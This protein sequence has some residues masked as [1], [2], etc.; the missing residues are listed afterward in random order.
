[1]PNEEVLKEFNLY[2]L[3]DNNPFDLSG[4]EAQRLALS[5]V[6]S[7]NPDI[8]LLDEPTKSLDVIFKKE[9]Y[10]IL[11]KIANSGKTIIFVTH[12]L[13][14]AGRYADEVSFLFDGKI[15]N[16]SNRYNFFSSLNIYTTSLSRLTNGKIV[17]IDDI[18]VEN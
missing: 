14:F 1:M 9:L 6:L 2:N 8:L 10:K 18:E 12:D 4:G 5:K 16:T 17:S 15:I 3:K 11:R 13:E 7:L